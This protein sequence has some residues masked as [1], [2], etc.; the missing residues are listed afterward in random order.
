MDG[1]QP[2]P[3]MTVEQ[4][5]RR[6]PAVA[7]LFLQG[8]MAC[9]GCALARLCTLED[10]SRHYAIPVQDLLAG[11]REA[12]RGAE[13][14]ETMEARPTE[15]ARPAESA[16]PYPDSRLR[17]V[18]GLA[19]ALLL[20]APLAAC[21]GRAGDIDTTLDLER[22]L[23]SSAEPDGATGAAAPDSLPSESSDPSGLFGSPARPE[24]PAPD[25]ELTDQGG[26]P[27]RLTDARGQAVALF[28][29]YTHCPDVCPQTLSLVSQGLALLEP[30]LGEAVTV[31]F[32]SLDPERDDAARLAAYLEGFGPRFVG[33]T[34]AMEDLQRLAD[35]YGVRFEKE[36]GATPE[37]YTLAHGGRVYLIDAEGQLRASFIG[38]FPPEELA[39]DL[40][41]LLAE[42]REPG[43]A[44]GGASGPQART[45]PTAIG[46]RSAENTAP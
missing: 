40:R 9:L 34:G 25:F 14:P 28:F 38:A 12:I 3:G 6:W 20:T 22:V 36:P 41:L 21:S 42:R 15:S 26:Q 35:G 31:A 23:D 13:P 24:R 2:E 8:R 17:A 16:R 43:A 32:V 30:E 4:L 29:G 45:E 10:V 46:S 11:L 19:L 27:W 33:M 18:A 37:D 1:E 7:G 44:L 5:V 39:S